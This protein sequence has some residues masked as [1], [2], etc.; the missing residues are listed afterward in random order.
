MFI[1]KTQIGD[2]IK[3]VTRD[4]ESEPR[5]LSE[6]DGPWLLGL[7]ERPP[8]MN[9]IEV[10]PAVPLHV[11]EALHDLYRDAK[12]RSFQVLTNQI[13]QAI[14]EPESARCARLQ[15]FPEMLRVWLKKNGDRGWVYRE[16]GGRMVPYLVVGADYF[17]ADSRNKTPASVR[18]TFLASIPD[19]SRDDERA[20]WGVEHSDVSGKSVTEIMADHNMV[21]ESPEL[22]DEHD[23]A[24]G[25]YLE[26]VKHDL[27]QF[28]VNGKAKSRER[29]SNSTTELSGDKVVLDV[30]KL[31]PQRTL[32]MG[33]REPMK[34]HP[35]PFH[36]VV[37]FFHLARHCMLRAHVTDVTLYEWKPEIG[38]KLVLPQH[39][40]DLI[41]VL[42]EDG[43]LLAEDIVE[44][45]TGGTLVLCKGPA[46]VGKTLTAEVYSEVTQRPLYRVHSGQL[47]VSPEDA[48]KRLEGA[49]KRASRYNAVML[50]DEADV[51][52]RTR[53]DNI[54][55][56]AM[57]SVFL[58]MLEYWDGL[59]FMTTNRS[60]DIDEAIISR[61]MA[62]ISYEKPQSEERFA[63]WTILAKQ[64]G[65]A[66][67]DDLAHELVR[68]FKNVSGRDIKGLLRLTKRYAERR[69]EPYTADLFRRMAMF[70]A[71]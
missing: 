44:G 30:G 50:I 10:P 2:L 40:R 63:L 13:I 55:Q 70:R 68:E 71:S 17:S 49:F 37:D 6:K 51:F 27:K 4:G 3:R 21:P 65:V 18:V 57:T 39:H 22:N 66:M 58:R 41:E 28:Q 20:S 15:A 36:P 48:E 35:V 7:A 43:E 14:R 1:E 12:N 53:G 60:G 56:N 11:Y 61:C 25:R 69:G 9:Q 32:A 34:E 24:C 59:L 45:K 33:I 42:T 62:V 19:S 52:V 67:T 26:T 16:T 29:Y 23:A 38:T 46:G 31:A 8:Y 47:G 54:V 64:F 5:E